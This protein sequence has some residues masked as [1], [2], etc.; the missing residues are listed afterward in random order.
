MYVPDLI[1]RCGIAMCTA[2]LVF[3]LAPVATATAAPPDRFTFDETDSVSFTGCGGEQTTAVIHEYGGGQIRFMPDGQAYF[4]VK[5]QG[6]VALTRTS[7]GKTVNLYADFINR[8][9]KITDNG[10]GTITILSRGIINERDYAPDGTLGLRTVG[11]QTSVFVIDLN[12]TPDNF[13]DDVEV[14]ADFLGFTGR[15]D[16]AQTDF[17]DWFLSVTG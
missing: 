17:C 16:R 4:W 15:D 14:S 7:T 12:G 6:H 13:D 5:Y 8:D 11:Q 1:R 9:S 10:D 3:A 2:V